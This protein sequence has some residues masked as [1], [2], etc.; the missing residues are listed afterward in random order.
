[1]TKE[2]S[3]GC[4]SVELVGRGSCLIGASMIEQV[5]RS[6]RPLVLVLDILLAGVIHLLEQQWLTVFVVSLSE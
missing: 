3:F 6:R 2:V 1:M 4:G 5:Y